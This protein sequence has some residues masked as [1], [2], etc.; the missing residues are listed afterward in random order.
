MQKTL[1]ANTSYGYV[2][3]VSTRDYEVWEFNVV[4]SSEGQLLAKVSFHMVGDA[5]SKLKG[6]IYHE[7]G[8]VSETPNPGLSQLKISKVSPHR[9]WILLDSL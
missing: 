7:T 3:R 4:K 9:N 6:C 2:K 8:N 5:E 1:Y